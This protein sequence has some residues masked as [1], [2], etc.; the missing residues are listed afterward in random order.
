MNKYRNV[1]TEVDAIRFDS[2]REA[3]RYQELKLLERAGEIRDLSLQ[4]RLP[5]EVNGEKVCTYICDF[6]YFEKNKGLGFGRWVYEDVK[7]KRTPV[8]L[9]KKKL[10]KAILGIEILET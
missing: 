2:K 5:L 3:A 8:Y 6:H 4:V 10:V 9:L 1:K 7:G